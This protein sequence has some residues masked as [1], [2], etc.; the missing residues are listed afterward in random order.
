MLTIPPLSRSFPSLSSVIWAANLRRCVSANRHR[1]PQ[2]L[3]IRLNWILVIAGPAFVI[4]G[5]F[6]A[7]WLKRADLHTHER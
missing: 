5:L 3:P 1:H 2:P 6:L 7:N 4:A